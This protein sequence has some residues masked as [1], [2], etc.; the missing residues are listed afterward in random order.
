MMVNLPCLMVSCTN[1]LR[2]TCSYTECRLSFQ[3]GSCPTEWTT[4]GYSSCLFLILLAFFLLQRNWFFSGRSP[5]LHPLVLLGYS[6][7]HTPSKFTGFLLSR[8][9]LDFRYTLEPSKGLEYLMLS[10]FYGACANCWCGLTISPNNFGSYVV[11]FVR[12]VKINLSILQAITINDCI[13]FSGFSFLV[14]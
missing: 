10:G 1:F 7:V 6:A 5:L 2:P 11:P 13:F 4:A 12:M 3:T 14:V 8:T 9:L